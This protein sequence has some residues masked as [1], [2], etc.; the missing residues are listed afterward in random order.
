L[1]EDILINKP[2]E[3]WNGGKIKVLFM[4]YEQEF[5]GGVLL[6]DIVY[7]TERLP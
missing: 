7:T 6:C 1:E 2:R 4:D 5:N 3:L